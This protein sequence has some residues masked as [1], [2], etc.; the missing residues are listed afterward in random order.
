MLTVAMVV[1]SGYTC[2]KDGWS[3]DLSYYF[4]KKNTD[5]SVLK[6]FSF[7]GNCLF[8]PPIWNR[9]LLPL[10]SVSLKSVFTPL[11]YIWAIDYFLSHSTTVALVLEKRCINR[12]Q[13]VFCG[14]PA[15]HG[16]E[17]MQSTQA[18]CRD[19][20]VTPFLTVGRTICNTREA[21]AR[22]VRM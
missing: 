16:E 22:E 9:Q 12:R 5:Q 6:H 8:S 18:S 7:L 13:L 15:R 2:A 10:K 14:R 11:M 4:F 19:G 21:C 20:S 17:L 1:M 3:A